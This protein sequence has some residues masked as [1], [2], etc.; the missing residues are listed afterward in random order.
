MGTARV[1]PS[2]NGSRRWVA[3]LAGQ[4]VAGALCFPARTSWSS[5]VFGYLCLGVSVLPLI[6]KNWILPPWPYKAWFPSLESLA[7]P[8]TFLI[9]CSCLLLGAVLE[10]GRED[11]GN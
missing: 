11:R 6:D 7:G 5:S 8:L 1:L 9:S 2:S 4:N 3:G 10:G